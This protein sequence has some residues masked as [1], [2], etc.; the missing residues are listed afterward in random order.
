MDSIR[1]IGVL[2]VLAWCMA[3]CSHAQVVHI[4]GS[5][6]RAMKTMDGGKQNTPVSIPVYIFD[7]YTEAERQAR[8]YRTQSMRQ[9]GYATVKSNDIATP[10]YEGHFEADIA[11]GGALLVIDE[12]TPRVIKIT[13]ALKYDIQLKSDSADGILLKN[14]D[15]YGE[16][17][18]MQ[19]RELPPI[20]DGPNLHWNVSVSIPAYYGNK[21]ARLI[22][23][24]AVIDCQTE[25]TIQYL[26]PMVF[27]GKQY[28]LA[29]IRRKSFDFQR[30]DSLAKY[31]QL[32]KLTEK[33][34]AFQWETTYPKPN[35]EH[36]YKWVSDM[37]LEDY[38]HVYYDDDTKE[39]TCN[40][41][42]PWKMLDI[43]FARK[44]IVLD[45]RYYEQAKAQLRETD[46]DL[47]LTFEI[48][49]A[50]LTDDSV[51]MQTINRLVRE[52]RSYGRQLMNVK[53]QGTASP[54]GNPERNAEL[55]NKRAQHALT[56]ISQY[57]GSAS[58]QVAPPKVYSWMDV[59]DS[60][61][62]RGL[63]SVATELREMVQRNAMN[64]IRQLMVETPEMNQI[65]QNLRLM[66]CSY[67]IRQNKVMDPDEALWAYYHDKSY[68]EGGDN[69]FSNGD[70]YHLF[71]QITDSAELRK[72][73]DRAYRELRDRTTSKYS[74]FAAYIANRVASYAIADD[75]VNTDILAPYIDMKSSLEAQRQISFDN[76][77]KYTINRR[78]L[79]ANQAIMYFRAMKLGAASHLADKLPDTEDF[80]DIKM[81]TDLETL[82]FKQ[83]KTASEQQRAMQ[84]LNYAMQ[85]SDVN[86]AVLSFELAP[87]LG[88]TYQEVEPL[89]NALPD[90]NPKKWYM[91]GVIAANSSETNDD[92]FMEL[93]AK[94]GAEKAIL[95]KENQT[96]SFIAFMQHC[97][98]LD[99]TYYTKY[100]LSDANI[101]DEIK[102]K[103]PYKP[104]HA[105]E[106]REKF[107]TL[108]QQG[109][110]NHDEKQEI[111]EGKEEHEDH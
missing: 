77:Y 58:M 82:F 38:T 5:V 44:D 86:R 75:E 66:K 54:D 21:H 12:G 71:R 98:D 110:R 95:M 62:G 7:N 26:E 2:F 35:P 45:E 22:F 108:M 31:T 68:G 107:E 84:A 81:F 15:I 64:G 105:Q 92:D 20:D 70:Y 27:D 32:Q 9:G 67:T 34:F 97:F 83:N 52:L 39:G 73:T 46:R 79:V 106:Y 101:S 14:T 1:K 19:M 4:T 13:S 6:T 100:Y 109:Q 87:E 33:P 94:Y 57:V 42:K 11:S 8:E 48:G 40:S 51:N 88:K 18:G 91:K 29:Q 23:Q 10:D 76:E 89:I 25:D 30:N 102:K 16:R 61:D 103:Y 99:S 24:P 111:Q 78:E 50:I 65:L 72:L 36:S 37:L 56:M 55:A 96:P 85:T 59:A 93:V 28:H 74:P 47:Q 3:L 90:D 53:I 80:R 104:E 63:N 60:L 43:G 69:R 49:K 17:R 41:R